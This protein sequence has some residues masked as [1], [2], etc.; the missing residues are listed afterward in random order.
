[1]RIMAVCHTCRMQHSCAP[2]S[3]EATEFFSRHAGHHIESKME[4]PLVGKLRR[5]TGGDLFR[6]LRRRNGADEIEFSRLGEAG[7]S[8]NANVKQAFQSSQTFTLT[9]ANLTNS[10]TA[11]W[12]SAAVDNTTNLYDDALVMARLAAVNTAPANSR[13]IFFFA[14]GLVDDANSNYTSTGDGIPDGSVGTITFPDVSTAVLTCPTLGVIP[15]PTQNKALNGGP[16]SVAQAFGGI[17]P[18]KWCITMVNYSGMTLS[19]TAIEYRGVY[20]TVA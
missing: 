14:H 10:A 1:M 12:K 4:T 15:Y 20:W 3:D 5:L 19:V 16:W 17:L 8:G 13:A 6:F 9:S 11:G 2:R 18:P 7:Y